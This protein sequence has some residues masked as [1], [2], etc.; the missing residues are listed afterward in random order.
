MNSN[1]LKNLANKKNYYSAKY[2]FSFPNKFDIICLL[3]HGHELET[4]ENFMKIDSNTEL[5]EYLKSFDK[6]I[7][8]TS[9]D[10]ENFQI[11]KW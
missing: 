5:N 11:K 1:Y 7:S 8:I 9:F 6:K 10:E 3:G 2:P 4:D